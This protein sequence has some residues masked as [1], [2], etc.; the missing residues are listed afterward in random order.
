MTRG[1]IPAMD[2]AGRLQNM[3]RGGIALA[4]LLLVAAMTL[5]VLRSGQYDQ[6][7]TEYTAARLA[8]R[9]LEEY[10]RT[11]GVEILP[12]A[13][14]GF[15][16]YDGFGSAL[17]TMGVAPETIRPPQDMEE[18][19]RS[20][21]N[22]RLLRLV[23]PHRGVEAPMQP[24]PV[25][26]ENRRMTPGALPGSPRRGPMMAS[27]SVLIDVDVSD[28]TR[29]QL[30]ERTAVVGAAIL[31]A[32]VLALIVLL[33][34]KLQVARAER[35]HEAR[36]VQLGEA[37]RTLAH[38]IKNPLT[39]AQ[40]QSALL[41]RSIDPEHVDRLTIIDDELGRIRRLTDQVRE[42]LRSDTGD[43]EPVADGP[44]IREIASRQQL[45]L[46]VEG[47]DEAIAVID[48]QR[49]R[50]IIANLLEN[51]RDAMNGTGGVEV[52]LRSRR[53]FLEIS[54]CDRGPGIPREEIDRVFDPFFSTK[55]HG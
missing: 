42:F 45:A 26:P 46:K 20:G 35:E 43:P 15:G 33:Y 28:A 30:L 53:N 6:L 36:L 22:L 44:V 10:S 49:L 55:V 48:P 40:M 31:T 1:T 13:V 7:Q 8:T 5:L 18:I 11:G 34:R 25:D 16:V 51:A 50:S 21:R 47:D 12:T 52:H 29:R 27:Q 24:Q 3:F 19:S 17:L 54:V 2:S 41:R 39:A 32:V 4:T 9:L 37:A 38:E 14:T 23:G